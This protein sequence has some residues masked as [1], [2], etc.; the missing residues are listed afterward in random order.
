MDPEEIINSSFTNPTNR[1]AFVASLTKVLGTSI[2]LTSPLI[3][4]AGH[5]VPV[6]Q[7]VTVGDVMALFLKEVTGAPFDKTVDT[8]K[9]GS[10]SIKVTGI[11]TTMFATVEVIQKAV[12]AGANFIIAHE[13][14]FYNHQD[15]T[16]WLENDDVYQYKADLL[17]KHNIAVWRNHDY[18]HTHQP[19]GVMTGLIEALEWQ[20]YYKPETRNRLEIPAMSLKQ[21]IAHV[22][23]KLGIQMVRVI[24][25]PA[26]SCKRV[27]LLP[28]AAGGR[29]QITEIMK[30]KPDVIL[31]GESSEWET[32]EYVRD[33]RAKGHATSLVL[34][35]HAVSE[36]PG[37][38]WMASWL[39]QKFSGL[40]IT[41]IPS[42]NPL[43]F[44]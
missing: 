21:V 28:G 23:Q 20:K 38:E 11:V 16:I 9:S 24:G 15:E 27:L 8:L 18:I 3:T 31:C 30:E 32:V 14:T 36:E 41:H 5:G 2:L 42:R 34:L 17:K 37:A 26:Q 40:K 7:S 10:A 12:K 35:G 25:D 33:A 44:M 43:S 19:D 4:H 6:Q 22:K 13:P 29:N 39:K 1:R